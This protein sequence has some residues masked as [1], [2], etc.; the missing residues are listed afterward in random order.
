LGAARGPAG[1]AVAYALKNWAALTRYVTD[2]DLSHRQQP[3]RAQPGLMWCCGVIHGY[4]KIGSRK[5]TSLRTRSSEI[6]GYHE[7]KMKNRCDSKRL[8]GGL[9]PFYTADKTA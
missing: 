7:W 4:L 6:F 3:H 1:Q 8:N 5:V 2:G 9:G